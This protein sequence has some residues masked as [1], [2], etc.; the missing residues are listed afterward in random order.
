MNDL[1]PQQRRAIE[2]LLVAR[3]IAD[4]A[5]QA[6]VSRRTLHSWLRN[7]QFCAELHT[8]TNA[9]LDAAV[10]RLAALTACAVDA[11]EAVLQGERVPVG[12]KI[13]AADVVLARLLQ[14]RE[15]HEFERRL[16]ALEEKFEREQA[17]TI[18]QVGTPAS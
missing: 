18:D 3:S 9:A 14:L 12:A 17:T 7:A 5:K 4:A 13:R 8:A 10:R 1:S 6:G 15:M 2:A 11:L 16:R